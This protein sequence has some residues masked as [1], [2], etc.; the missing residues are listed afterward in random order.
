MWIYGT[1][2]VFLLILLWIFL[3]VKSSIANKK[4]DYVYNTRGK[5]NWRIVDESKWDNFYRL[6]LISKK[7]K[8]ET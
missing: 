1:A 2:S 5:G 4:R 3:S 8:T 7:G 6:L